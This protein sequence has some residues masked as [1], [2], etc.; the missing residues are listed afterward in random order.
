MTAIRQAQEFARGPYAEALYQGNALS[1]ADSDKIATQLSGIIGLSPAFIKN[2]NLRISASRFRKELLRDQ[3]KILG[4]YD[5]RFEGPD[6][7]AAG[8]TPG[9]D[10]SDTG[11]S[12]AYVWRRFITILRRSSSSSAR[13][14]TTTAAPI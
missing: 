4:R 10:P 13:M 2:S 8:D 6:A 1:D 3:N 12:G 9:F 11:I 14:P 5:A 7:E